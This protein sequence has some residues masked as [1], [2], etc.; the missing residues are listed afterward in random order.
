MTTVLG[1]LVGVL[2]V[3]QTVVVAMFLLARDR[4]EQRHA[5]LLEAVEGHRQQERT[6]LLQRIQAPAD[7]AVQYAPY[8]PPA[9]PMHVSVFDDEK[10]METTGASNG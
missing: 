9:E 8:E 6:E 4:A 7:A 3:T 5:A 1:V 10:L 2:A